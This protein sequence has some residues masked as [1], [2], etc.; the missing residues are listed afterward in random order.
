MDMPGGI[1]ASGD[2]A[3]VAVA[4][5]RVPPRAIADAVPGDHLCCIYGSDDEQRA[6]LVPYLRIGLERGEK[7]LYIVDARTA[8]AVLGDLRDDGDRGADGVDVDACLASGQL[9][10]LTRHDTYVRD[11]AFDPVA[12]ISMLRQATEQAVA[13]G[14]PALRVTGEMTWALRGLPGAERLIE[15]ECLLN[16]FFPGSRALAICQY[17][18][19]RFEPGLLLDVLRTHPYVVVGA[20]VVENPYYLP[21]DAFR[22]E[23]RPGADLDRWMRNLVERRRDEDKIG[24]AAER[25]RAIVDQMRDGFSMLDPNGVHLGVNT[26]LC[27]MTGFTAHELVGAGPPHP[28]WPPEELAAIASAF[29]QTMAGTGRDFELTFMRKDGSR[30]PVLVT[31]SIV[32]NANG[33]PEVVIATVRDETERRSVVEQ[34]ERAAHEWQATFDAA[35]DAIWLLD[36]EQRVVR[37][38]RAADGMFGRPDGGAIGHHCWEIAHGT[39]VPIAGCPVLRARAT[40]RRETM[41]LEIGDRWFQVTADPIVDAARGFEGAVHIAT[42][43]TE[44]RQTEEALRASERRYRE[45]ADGL[46]DLVYAVDREMRYTSWNRASELATG[47][48]ATDALGRTMYEV[49][50][51]FAGTDAERAVMDVLSTGRPRSLAQEFPVLGDMRSFDVRI[52]PTPGGAAFLSRDVTDLVRS[53]EVLRQREAELAEGQRIAHVGSWTWDPVTGV[54]TWSDELYRIYG[55]EP[56]GPSITDAVW[57]RLEGAEAFAER[58]ATADRAFETGEAYESAYAITRP[59]GTVRHLIGRGE[60]VRG[61][62]GSIVGVRGTVIDRTERRE[63]EGRLLQAQKMETVGHLAGGVA[64]D[65]NNL[66]GVILGNA[67]LARDGLDADDPRRLAMSEIEDAARRGA[68]LTRQLLAFSHQQVASPEVL[69]INEVTGE[70]ERMLGR[71]IGESVRLTFVA[72]EPAG[73]VRADRA[74]VGQVL[75]NLAVNARDAMPT[76]GTLLVRTGNVDLGDADPRRPASLKPGRYV[77][78]TFTDSGTGIDAATREHL[79]EPF[80]TT[81]GVGGGSGLGLATAQGIACQGGGDLILVDSAPGRGSTFTLFLPAVDDPLPV[82]C[83][84]TTAQAATG[85]ETILLVEDD[86]GVR[87]LAQRILAGAGYTVL[88]AADG[89]EALALL[90]GHRDPVDLVFSDVVMPG[91]GGPE[92]AARVAE[93]RPGTAVL[94][95]S[96]YPGDVVARSGRFPPGAHFIGKPFTAAELTAKVREA[97]GR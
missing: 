14:Y 39:T 47:I 19:R 97:I 67:E 44:R 64:H 87:R 54:L 65:F 91:M 17:D 36:G 5:V 42:D 48:A 79:F 75:M 58:S 16:E 56:G 88:D 32:R 50:P 3:S 68:S 24:A 45:L 92:L 6:A 95:M 74:Q 73:R 70:L 61:P 62:D 11:G 71:L 12:M 85:T 51:Q 89:A 7:V 31:P 59:D 76:G 15:Y 2:R 84:A 1:D 43:I 34:T 83:P 72:G 80:F 55:L 37:S 66:L 86:A 33:D 93:T 4:E 18:R 90:A 49:L 63:A 96:G 69:D 25:S 60:A 78:V 53:T 81:K 41:D 46:P 29:E 82:R 28:Y 38:N 57:A 20:E 10:L 22:S 27:A 8:E 13:E 52:A 23:N 77:T 40:L 35:N 94:L 30:F 9:A 26:A 21:P